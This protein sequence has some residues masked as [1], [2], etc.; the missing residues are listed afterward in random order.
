MAV[1]RFFDMIGISSSN[2]PFHNEGLTTRLA[3]NPLVETKGYGH[4]SWILNRPQWKKVA[5]A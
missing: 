5:V 3:I 1:Y 2:D 4:P